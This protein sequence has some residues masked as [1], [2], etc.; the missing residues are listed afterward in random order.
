MIEKVSICGVGIANPRRGDVMVVFETTAD[1]GEIETD[2]NRVLFY[3]RGGSNARE[4]EQFGSVKGTGR[5]NHLFASE[6]SGTLQSLDSDRLEWIVSGEDYTGDIR[7]SQDL[8]IR[9]CVEEERGRRYAYATKGCV[10]R[11]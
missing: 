2:R 8:Q 7:F 4:K 1:R 10:R 6:K 5:E 3:F 9:G 11:D